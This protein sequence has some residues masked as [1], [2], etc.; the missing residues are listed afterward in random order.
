MIISIKPWLELEQKPDLTQSLMRVGESFAG[1]E[2]SSDAESDDFR[3]SYRSYGPSASNIGL[4]QGKRMEFY[5]QPIMSAEILMAM[6]PIRGKQIFDGT[7][8]GGG[9]SELFLSEGAHVI[10]CDQDGDALEHAK[11]RLESYG[12]QFLTVRGNFESIDSL[13]A[14]V[15][16]EEVDG[17]LLDLG[18][19][20]KQ[21]D[22]PERGFSFRFDG[23]L[24]MRMD[25][26]AEFSARDLVNDWS[27][28]EMTRI[29]REYGEERHA[30]RAAK[31]IEKAREKGAINRTSEL[32]D[33]VSAVIPKV[34]KKNPATRVFQAIRIAV[35]RE[36]EVL[37]N[38]L[39]KSV[40]H[41]APGGVLSIITFHSL[42]DRIVKHFMRRRSTPFLDRP[43]WP[44]PRENPEYCLQLPHRR[45]IVPS[46]EEVESNPRARSAK[47]RVAVKL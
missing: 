42:E 7:L 18:V 8:G 43:E 6:A 37:E 19:S 32:V 12:D 20:S 1:L 41:L 30:F 9:H 5:H 27:V 22:N 28:D 15:G 14:Q 25:D 16:V 36:L 10:G 21:L 31:A 46:K 44:E 40:N 47:L 35:N 34:S 45:A 26:R 38:T 29:F 33:I 23:P 17:I 3:M 2:L 11:K 24:D 4:E 39:E 13:L